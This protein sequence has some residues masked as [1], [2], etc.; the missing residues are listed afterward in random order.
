MADKNSIDTEAMEFYRTVGD[1]ERHFN[2]IEFEVRKLASAWLII[3][4]GAIAFLIRGDLVETQSLI[5]AVPLI[6]FIALLV[7]TGLFLLWILDQLVYHNLLDA[8]FTT[9]LDIERS[10][11]DV[12]P[13]RMQ[14]LNLTGGAGVARYLKLFYLIPMAVL[15]TIG[16]IACYVATERGSTLVILMILSTL[17]TITLPIWV[18]VKSSAMAKM[19]V[20]NRSGPGDEEMPDDAGKIIANWKTRL[21]R[22]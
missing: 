2:G 19:R 4:F 20:E 13:V 1:Y 10:N 8:I 17:A 14:M 16:S 21:E 22:N 12:P 6:V 15:A 7:Q 5:G 9:A 3:G 18:I 11:P